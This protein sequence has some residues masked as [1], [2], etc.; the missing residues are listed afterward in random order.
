MYSHR[1][2]NIIFPNLLYKSNLYNIN[3]DFYINFLKKVNQ[4]LIF[5]VIL[6]DFTKI[7]FLNLNFKFVKRSLNSKFNV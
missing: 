4:S 3:A 2:W 5:K 6:L 1:S 7:I